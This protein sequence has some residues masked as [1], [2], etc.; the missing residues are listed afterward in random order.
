MHDISAAVLDKCFR[1]VCTKEKKSAVFFLFCLF[2]VNKDPR[3]AVSK[4]F[5]EFC[6]GNMQVSSVVSEGQY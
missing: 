1:K 4:C 5:S 3:C 6:L 2:T